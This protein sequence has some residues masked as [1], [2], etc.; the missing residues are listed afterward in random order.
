M[1]RP[2]CVYKHTN[3]ANGK[4]YIGITYDVEYRWRYGGC[5]YKSNRHFWQ[6]IKKYG[7]DGF[8]HEILYDELSK[9]AACECEIRLISEHRATEREF[10]YNKSVGG[11]VPLVVYSG[12]KH[13][14]YGKHHSE[15]ARTKMSDAKRGEKHP[16]FA[17]HLPE[18]TRRKIGDANRGRP[19]S[20]EQKAQLR[21][22]NLGKK[23]SAET[24]AKMSAA[25]KARKRGPDIGKKISEAKKKTPVIQLTREGEFVAVWPSVSSA[26]QATGL[27][28]GQICKC[29]KGVLRTTGGFTWKYQ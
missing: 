13:P 9:E 28:T 23:A 27:T 26:A 16:W 5:A 2:Y 10:G 6:A 3:R 21:K 12:E 18:E 14:M 15:E 29:C 4:V 8:D 7:W 24:R 22:A 1:E 25:Q 17:K 19:I 20:E 11:D